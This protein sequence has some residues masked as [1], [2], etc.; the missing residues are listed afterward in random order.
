MVRIEHST[1]SFFNERHPGDETALLTAGATTYLRAANHSGIM[2]PTVATVIGPFMM[3][4]RPAGAPFVRYTIPAFE[5]RRLLRDAKATGEPFEL[6][7]D[8]LPG[9]TGGE[10]WRAHASGRRIKL[11]VHGPLREPDCTVLA[12]GLGGAASCHTGDLALAP[13]PT[14]DWVRRPFEAALGFWQFWPSFAI[15]DDGQGDVRCYGS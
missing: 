12:E 10:R 4:R 3:P 15:V 1:S 6:I 11:T 5:L 2:N 7:Y 14:R 8:S 13:F 9:A